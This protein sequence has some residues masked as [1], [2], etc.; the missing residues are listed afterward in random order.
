MSR[1]EVDRGLCS[2]HARCHATAPDVYD[3]DDLGYVVVSE[4]ELPT[5][6]VDD[7]R[8]GVDACPE[9]ALRIVP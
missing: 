5:E 7:A 1:V 8:R 9:R 4:G 2:G 3:V 6:L